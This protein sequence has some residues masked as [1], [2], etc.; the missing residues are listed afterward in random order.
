L[1]DRLQA[2]ERQ[3]ANPHDAVIVRPVLCRPFV[4]RRAELAYL[5][6]RRLEAGASRGGLIF[7]AGDAGLGKTRLIDEFCRSLAYSRWRITRGPCREYGGRPYGPILDA[8]A[9]V[10]PG[11][12]QV[13]AA[14]S[15]RQ[16]FDAIVDRFAEIAARK[17]LVVVIEDLHWA[18]AATL[19]LLAYL[20]TKLDRMRVLLLASFRPGDLHAEHPAAAG[21]EKVSRSAR[22]GRIELAPL[23]GLEL[24]TFIDEALS[25]FT[26][27]DD[28]RR[29]IALT[30]EG[31]PFFTEEL[32][33]NAVQEAAEPRERNVRVPHSVRTT[34]L[35]R[36]R[37]FDGDDRRIITQA[38]VIGRTFTLELLA[39]VAELNVERVVPAL[40]RARDFQLIEELEPNV[41]RFRHGLTRE[42]ICG[43]FLQTELRPLHRRIAETLEDTTSEKPAIEALAFHW[44]AAGDDERSYRYNDLAGDAARAVYAH[45]DAI[46]FYQRA[47]EAGG[48]E[49][50][51]RGAALEKIA[52]LRLILSMAEEGLATYRAAADAYQRAGA[53]EREAVCR[54]REAMTAYTM[55]LV[56]T[57][58]SLERMLERVDKS[59]F[60]ACARLHLGIAWILAAMRFPSRAK[61]HLAQVDARAHGIATDIRVRYHNVAACVATD[62]GELNDFRREHAAW[63]EAA[64]AHGGGAIAGAY[65]NGAKFFASFCLHEEARANIQEALTIARDVKSRHAEECAHA[66]AALVSLVSG[67]LQGARNALD[68]VPPTTDNRV[69]LTFARAAGTAVATYTGDD[70]LIE[71]W[72]DGFDDPLDSVTEIE[73][74]YGF[75]EVLARRGRLRDAQTLLHRVLP[76]CEM[77][78]GQVLALLAIAR[79]GATE[80]R[81]RAREYLARA[82]ATSDGLEGAALSLF[83]AICGCNGDPERAKRL[84]LEAADGFRRFRTPLLEAQALE[85]GGEIQGAL[86]LYRRCG[87]TYDIGRLEPAHARNAAIFPRPEER[88][89]LAEMAALSPREREI[90]TLAADGS[91]NLDIAQSLSISHK[92]VE[93][94]LGSAFQKLGV[95]SR[96]ELRAYLVGS[97]THTTPHRAS[98][99]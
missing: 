19:D 3:T 33:K 48:L 78:R 23:A 94:H 92:T 31:N 89:E 2:V 15:K 13:T 35:E 56:D 6:E 32:L 7:I 80:D 76:E 18:D 36:L 72:F 87:A 58:A 91:S 22:A 99:G 96:R 59:E 26:L 85:L 5:K 20:G 30:G 77:V 86:A 84:A 79:H 62:L 95:S 41:F 28:R 60:L 24:R 42:A 17:A 37:P 50:M 55:Q 38:A 64:R 73:C 34:L 82:A 44:W 71:T 21:I 88:A 12:A 75:A 98:V 9:S 45:E 68:A 74:A 90:V 11:V 40:R 57:S 46:A 61:A 97:P 81:V 39:S 65:Y 69:N 4:G 16:Y 25:G 53:F 70:A 51:Q 43:N 10:D 67:D 66:T 49:P 52:N 29:A 27:D 63:Q 1:T 8:L 93:K 14:E 83:D 47:L 54:V